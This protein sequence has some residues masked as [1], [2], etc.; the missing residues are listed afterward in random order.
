MRL[1]D[2]GTCMRLA[3]GGTCMRL[4]DGGTCLRAYQY[5]CWMVSLSDYI[6]YINHL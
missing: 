3:D 5:Y 6:L 4:T 1:A 2:G